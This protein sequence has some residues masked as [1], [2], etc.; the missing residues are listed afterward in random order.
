M[1]SVNAPRVKPLRS[2]QNGKEEEKGTWCSLNVRSATDSDVA[3]EKEERRCSMHASGK[4]NQ[5]AFLDMNR[6]RKKH[7]GRVADDNRTGT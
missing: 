7:K 6:I 3:P 5:P 2:S 1:H 4:R